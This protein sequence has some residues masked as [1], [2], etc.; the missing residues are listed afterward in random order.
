MAAY[1]NYRVERDAKDKH[2]TLIIVQ[3]YEEKI[4]E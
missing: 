3:Q 4:N 2:E 1:Y